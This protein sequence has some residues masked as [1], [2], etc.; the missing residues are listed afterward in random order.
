MITYSVT[1]VDTALEN[2]NIAGS[3]VINLTGVAAQQAYQVEI[4][5]TYSITS[6]TVDA[7]PY[8]EGVD[9]TVDTTTGI[10]TFIDPLNPL[11]VGGEAIVVTLE[12]P[13]ADILNDAALTYYNIEDETNVEIREYQVEDFEG[14]AVVAVPDMDVNLV[15]SVLDVTPASGNPQEF[16]PD[17]TRDNHSTAPN[18]TFTSDPVAEVYTITR[19]DAGDFTADGFAAGQTITV[20]GT[21]DNDAIYTIDSVTADT[22]TVLE[23]TTAEATVVGSR[24]AI[25]DGNVNDEW[26]AGGVITSFDLHNDTTTGD[27]IDD[28]T[29]WNDAYDRD[30]TALNGGAGRG[31]IVTFGVFVENMGSDPVFELR[32]GDVSNLGEIDLASVEVYLG[33]GTQVDPANFTATGSFAGGDVAIQLTGVSLAAGDANDDNIVDNTTGTNVAIITYEVTVRNDLDVYE[34]EINTATVDF[35]TA[36]DDGTSDFSVLDPDGLLTDVALVEGRPPTADLLKT[37]TGTS[38]DHTGSLQHNLPGQALPSSGSVTLI[39]DD[40]SASTLTTGEFNRARTRHAVEP[41]ELG[42]WKEKGG[43]LWQLTGG[44]LQ[45]PDALNENGVAMVVDL[46]SIIDTS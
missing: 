14:L 15:K 21:T 12:S 32:I 1:I 11:F 39:D 29:V 38:H 45:N 18:H 16:T 6:I 44:V 7:T 8:T 42:G 5:S 40:F 46:T 13:T 28:L 35:Y 2:D 23:W 26:T 25:G 27:G 41:G 34:Q 24:I 43:G 3:E 33:D 22:I 4:P 17:T 30:L 9:W 19:D 20:S 37:I 10:I 36:V 31:D